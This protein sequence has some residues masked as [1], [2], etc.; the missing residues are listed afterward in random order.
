M[1]CG[2]VARRLAVN[3]SV[4]LRT[5]ERDKGGQCLD[6]ELLFRA[7]RGGPEWFGFYPARVGRACN[8]LVYVVRSTAADVLLPYVRC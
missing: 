7:V 3:C 4:D 8:A 5:T 6:E 1:S 2:H